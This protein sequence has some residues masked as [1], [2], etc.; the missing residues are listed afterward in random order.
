MGNDDMTWNHRVIRHVYDGE[1]TFAIHE[2]FYDADGDPILCT[3]DAV[4]VWGNTIDEVKQILKWMSRAVRQPI[5][6]MSDFEKGGKYHHDDP[7][8]LDTSLDL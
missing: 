5:L 4:G 1:E 7:F 6:N 2:V 8:D 3:T